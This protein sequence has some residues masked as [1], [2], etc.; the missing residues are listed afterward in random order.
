M[1]VGRR[2]EQTKTVQLTSA[3]ET[4]PM[5]TLR[6]ECSNGVRTKTGT[7]LLILHTSAYLLPETLFGNRCFDVDLGMRDGMLQLKAPG[8]ERNAAVG[9][10]ARSPVLQV[11]FDGAAHLGK[12]T[13]YLM[14]AA[15]M[16]RH[17]KEEVAV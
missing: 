2:K 7:R 10:A 15:C 4:H 3:M 8:M 16:K 11:A 1:S 17:F 6:N 14:M 5:H 12:L 13:A 9:V